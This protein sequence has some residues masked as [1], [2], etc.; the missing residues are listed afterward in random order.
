MYDKIPKAISLYV[1]V[2]LKTDL[3]LRR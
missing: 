2:F 3:R 1:G